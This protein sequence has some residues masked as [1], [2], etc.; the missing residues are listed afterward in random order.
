MEKL[1]LSDVAVSEKMRKSISTRKMFD[2]ENVKAFFNDI[3]N[4]DVVK[5]NDFW[6]KSK[7]GCLLMNDNH[8]RYY[9]I[10]ALQFEALRRKDIEPLANFNS[11]ENSK[12]IKE[13]LNTN[14]IKIKTATYNKQEFDI[15]TIDFKNLYK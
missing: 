8:L 14:A 5:L 4:N 2:V 1:K 7:I 3:K 11:V 15:V 10:R 6:N 12:T 9:T 13:N